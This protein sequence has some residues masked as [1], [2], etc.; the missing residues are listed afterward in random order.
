MKA[1]TAFWIWVGFLAAG[2]ILILSGVL[3]PK[4]NAD[5]CGPSGL[6]V[7]SYLNPYVQSCNVWIP[8]VPGV[9]VPV[10]Q[11]PPNAPYPVPGIGGAGGW[12]GPQ[13]P[14]GWAPL[15]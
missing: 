4:A 13:P 1:T 5:M 2:L 10:V 8:F 7:L 3:S 12:L 15:G 11:Q 6:P 14:T 9:R